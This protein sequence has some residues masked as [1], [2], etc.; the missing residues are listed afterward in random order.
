MHCL[1]GVAVRCQVGM[2]RLSQ[3]TEVMLCTALCCCCCNVAVADG[4]LLV[5]DMT[6]RESFTAA[7]RWLH[8]ARENSNNEHLV[9]MVIANKADLATK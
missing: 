2:L 8:E 7:T 5:Y 6:N 9:V 4:C 1:S 3:L